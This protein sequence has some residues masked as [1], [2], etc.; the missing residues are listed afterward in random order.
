MILYLYKLSYIFYILDICIG[1]NT[2]Y[3]LRGIIIKER[4]KTLKFYF[5]NSLLIDIFGL[6]PLIINSD[7]VFQ[8][9]F[10]FQ[11]VKMK[12]LMHKLEQIVLFRDKW[13]GLKIKKLKNLRKKNKFY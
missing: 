13:K 4:M 5:K 7:N 10:F 9:L 8:F 3:Y 6:I 1:L 11:I 12:K 2:G